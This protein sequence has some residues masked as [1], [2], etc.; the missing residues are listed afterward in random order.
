MTCTVATI[1]QISMF[2]WTKHFAHGNT[3]QF[4]CITMQAYH[5]VF[6]ICNLL[7]GHPLCPTLRLLLDGFGTAG[8]RHAVTVIF[9]LFPSR[10]YF[11]PFLSQ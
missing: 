7:E 2:L 1:W 5:K 4:P 8:F 6:S 9:L 10:L 11:S 3:V